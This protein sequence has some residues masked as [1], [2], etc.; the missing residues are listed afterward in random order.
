MGFVLLLEGLDAQLAHD[1]PL[2]AQHLV[3][4]LAG[5]GEEGIEEGLE[6]VEG[7]QGDV[8]GG[9]RRL[10]VFLDLEPRPLLLQIAVHLAG[11]GHHLAQGGLESAPLQKVADDVESTLDFP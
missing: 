4:P 11:Q 1:V 3:Q 9:G 6:V 7:L 8:D 10:T 2:V 5:E